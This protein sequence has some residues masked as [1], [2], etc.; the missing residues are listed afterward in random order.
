MPDDLKTCS[1][2]GPQSLDKF[3]YYPGNKGRYRC[4]VCSLARQKLWEARHKD[5]VRTNYKRIREERRLRVLRHYAGGAI[6]F[7]DCCGED[8]IE[9]LSLD[10]KDGGGTKHRKEIGGGSKVYAWAE[11][12]NFPT[13]FRVLCHNCNQSYGAY[14][15]CPH[16]GADL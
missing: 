12:N 8:H 4:K 1:K 14:G 11:K 16:L 10:H 7:C 2:C 9:F 13:I 6:P 5:Q 15:W 3:Y